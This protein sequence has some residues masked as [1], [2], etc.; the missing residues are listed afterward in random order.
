MAFAHTNIV[1]GA[2]TAGED[3]SGKRYLAGVLNASGQIVQATTAGGRID[4]VILDEAPQ[5]ISASICTY[6]VER[7]ILGDTVA[8][9]DELAIDANGKFITAVADDVVVGKALLGGD[10]DDVATAQVHGA[11]TYTKSA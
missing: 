5:G 9:N 1:Y 7:V 2:T 6:G 4:G 8:I 10:A 11:G 3:L